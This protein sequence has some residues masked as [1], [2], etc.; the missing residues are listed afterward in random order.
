[1]ILP[2][3]F[4]N[5]DVGS[6]G[7]ART[8]LSAARALIAGGARV[9]AWDDGEVAC[10]ACAEL[11]ARVLP[12]ESWPWDRLA[13]L[14]L[15]PGVP[16]THPAPH[17]VVVAARTAKVEIIGDMELFARERS[18]GAE[19]SAPLLAITGTNGKST[20][21]ALIGHILNSRSEENTSELQS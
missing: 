19:R 12:Y 18:G 11:G 16:L 10:R 20:T 1:M 9:Y 5:Q 2:R 7:L 6:F 14:V 13:A 8:G 15:S 3:G 21:T 17:P 4:A